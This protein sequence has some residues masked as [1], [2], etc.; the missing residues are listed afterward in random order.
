MI[1]TYLAAVVGER[2]WYN[3]L[4]I[5]NTE[6]STWSLINV[7]GNAPT[8]RGCHTFTAHKDKDIYIFGGF[9]DNFPG[10]NSVFGDLC[11]LSLSRMKWKYPLFTGMPADRR[12]GHTT[13]I[14]RNTMYI[15]GG[16]NQWTHFNEMHSAKLINPSERKKSVLLMIDDITPNG[17]F[18][19]MSGTS[20][21][22]TCRAPPTLRDGTLPGEWFAGGETTFSLDQSVPTLIPDGNFPLSLPGL[23]SSMQ[24]HLS[25]TQSSYDTMT[26]NTLPCSR[27]LQT[28]PSLLKQNEEHGDFSG[29]QINAVSHV[30]K[31]FEIL[32]TRYKDIDRERELL[33]NEKM[34]ITKIREKIIVENN[35]R[36]KKLQK[37]IESQKL[38]NQEWLKQRTAEI[39][40]EKLETAQLRTQLEVEYQKLLQEQDNFRK[41]NKQLSALMKEY[42]STHSDSTV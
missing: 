9:N 10:V 21:R 8:E 26:T 23:G 38:Q 34:A 29:A 7:Q 17:K 39:E 12:Y 18:D 19:T 27:G 32:Q 13:F 4:Y 14:F 15:M 5:Y 31:A 37:M 25:E 28:M 2:I 11:K 33:E 40:R 20:M 16:V 1:F 42:K 6:N 41:R 35:N 36:Q 22:S 30:T 24:S 3:D